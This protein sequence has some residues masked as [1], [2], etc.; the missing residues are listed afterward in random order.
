MDK[1]D[2]LQIDLKSADEIRTVLPAKNVKDALKD[3]FLGLAEGRNVQPPQTMTVLPQDS[4]DFI[5]YL[6]VLQDKGVFGVKLS[7]YLTARSKRGEYPVTAYTLL[8]SLDS[9][10]PLLLCDSLELTTERT[11]A[12]TSLA[13][14]YLIPENAEKLAVIGSGKIARAHLRYV[15]G[16][17][18]WREIAVYSLSLSDE[19]ST[20]REREISQIKEIST[21][22]TT[23]D[24]AKSAVTNADVVMLCTS[25]GK[26]VIEHDWLKETVTV[27][28]ISTNVSRAH[29]IEP[30]TLSKYHVFCDYRK[31][32]PLSAGEMVIARERHGWQ[33]SEIAADLP[34]LVSGQH[35]G[36]KQ[37]SGQIFF[38]SIGL[39]IEDIAVAGLF[40]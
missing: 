28:S 35:R 6:G 18:P 38:R 21:I 8:M 29:E 14:D 30:A 22:A 1:K 9:G 17:R 34:E 23:M 20:D 3:A 27:T 26:T 31:T 32:A 10:Q 4:G 40:L 7:P 16:Q 33:D 39:G 25:S 36:E 19:K 12:T 24:N 5:T 11:A 13:L 37:V 15:S 2:P